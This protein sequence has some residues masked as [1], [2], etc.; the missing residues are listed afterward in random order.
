METESIGCAAMKLGA[1]RRIKEDVI[2]PGVGIVF[3]H[4]T[5]DWVTKGETIAMIHANNEDDA[6][7]AMEL[8]KRSILFGNLK[9]D[10]G[11]LIYELIAD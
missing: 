3:Y 7:E 1:G 5:G 4:K 10:T 2:D 9:I 6:D 8:L 11:P